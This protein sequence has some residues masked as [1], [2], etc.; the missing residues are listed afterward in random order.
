MKNRFECVVHRWRW[1]LLGAPTDDVAACHPVSRSRRG[2]RDLRKGAMR[3]S[4]TSF[5]AEKQAATEINTAD[6]DH[7]EAR[8]RTSRL[9]H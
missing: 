7:R 4:T 8:L 3:V 1:I 9:I 6:R 2:N 5:E